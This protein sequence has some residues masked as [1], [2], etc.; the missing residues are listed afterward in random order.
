MR[1]LSSFHIYLDAKIDSS[2]CSLINAIYNE[3]QLTDALSFYL[4]SEC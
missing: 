3:D 1:L 4:Q 2:K